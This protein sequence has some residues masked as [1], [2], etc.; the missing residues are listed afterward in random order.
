M[1]LEDKINLCIQKR[2][3]LEKACKD[4]LKTVKKELKGKS[5]KE[6]SLNMGKDKSYICKTL[7]REIKAQSWPVNLRPVI[8]IA[9]A[10][11]KAN[12]KKKDL[13]KI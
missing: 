9:K 1:N 13:E 11:I 5:V 6:M 7:P 10:L 2:L 8:E 12:Q 4:L 3:E